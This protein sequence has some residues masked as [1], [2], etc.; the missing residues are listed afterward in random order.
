MCFWQTADREILFLH[1]FSQYVSFGWKIEAIDKVF[2]EMHM[3]VVVIALWLFVVGVVVFSAIFCVLIILALYFF[4]W[5]LFYVHS[6]LEIMLS[7]FSLGSVCWI[8]FLGCL[9][10]GCFFFLFQSWQIVL[11]GILFWVGCHSLL[12]LVIHCFRLFYL[13]KFLSKFQPPF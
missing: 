7:V 10:C 5:S 9:C 2:I 8:Y 12:G 6:S 1:L 3:S 13:S 4:P 11:L